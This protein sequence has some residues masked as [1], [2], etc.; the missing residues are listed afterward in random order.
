MPSSLG[1]ERR[2][3]IG[4][5]VGLAVLVF[6]LLLPPPSGMEVKAWR[7]TAAITLIAVWWVSEAVHP[8]VTALVPLVLFP[9]LHILT[10][11]EVSAVYADQVIFLFLGGF[12]IAL[13]MEKWHLHRRIAL[14][15]LSRVGT[16]PRM[17]SLGFMGT[18]A[19]ISMCASAGVM[20]CSAWISNSTWP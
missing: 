16:S 17:L 6:L 9:L 8:S 5:V 11:Q 20:A 7:M 14:H 10:P 4:L 3:L 19:A 1:Y 15:I 13:A 12:L 2:Q 18:T